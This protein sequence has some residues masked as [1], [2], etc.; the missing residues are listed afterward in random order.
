LRNDRNIERNATTVDGRV[1]I[2]R[3]LANLPMS[4]KVPG[5]RTNGE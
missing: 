2:W 1:S 4:G 5:N 3:T